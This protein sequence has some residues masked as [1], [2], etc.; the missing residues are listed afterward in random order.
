MKKSLGILFTLLL[1][2]A[3]LLAQ[4]S[5]TGK[6]LFNVQTDAGSGSP[7]FDL[8]QDADGNITGEY[9][10]QLGNTEVTGTFLEG[11]LHLE[12]SVQG[13]QIF[14]DGEMK[15]GKLSGSVDL[16]GM[17]SGTWTAERKEE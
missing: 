4:E 9:Q 15:D 5:M 13:N 7:S 12:F 17:A 8:V 2:S 16:A 10:G 14:Y 6:W 3:P 1:L 11:K